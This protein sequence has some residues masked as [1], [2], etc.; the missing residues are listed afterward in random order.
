MRV[1]IADFFVVAVKFGCPADHVVQ[2]VPD[3]FLDEVLFEHLAV[4]DLATQGEGKIVI[5][6][7]YIFTNLHVRYHWIRTCLLY[8]NHTSMVVK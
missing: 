6:D 3:F 5:G 1:H 2:Q 8:E 4:A 7:L